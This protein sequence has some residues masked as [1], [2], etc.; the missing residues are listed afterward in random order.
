MKELHKRTIIRA[1]VWRL[2]AILITIPFTGFSTAV[3]VHVILTVAHY[4]YER[5]WLR[6]KWGIVEKEE[7]NKQKN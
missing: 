7:E 3:L 4:F 2:I 1:I 5:F 6:V